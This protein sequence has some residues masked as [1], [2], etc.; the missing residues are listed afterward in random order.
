[1]VTSKIIRNF[2]ISKFK[3]TNFKRSVPDRNNGLKI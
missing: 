1:M 3:T 2:A